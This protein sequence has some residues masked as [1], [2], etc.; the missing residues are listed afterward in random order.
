M[1]QIYMIKYIL[2]YQFL[3]LKLTPML[4]YMM[5]S[6]LVLK[7]NGTHVSD[8]TKNLQLKDM[9]LHVHKALLTYYS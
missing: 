6:T 4:N 7:V 9:K 5:E 8:E 3:S 2:G 1:V